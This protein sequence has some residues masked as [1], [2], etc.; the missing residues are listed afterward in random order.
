M[1]WYLKQ[2]FPF[3]YVSEFKSSNGKTYV[4]VWRQWFGRT[5]FRQRTFEIVK[6][7]EYEEAFAE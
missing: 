4:T 3:T 6:E 5:V 1:K 2:L 7:V